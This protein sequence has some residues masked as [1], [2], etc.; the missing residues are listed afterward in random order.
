MQG[1]DKMICIIEIFFSY[2]KAILKSG[3]TLVT[4]Q[5]AFAEVYE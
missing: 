5:T 2:V 1:E 3:Q 4:A